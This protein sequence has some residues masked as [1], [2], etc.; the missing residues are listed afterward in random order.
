MAKVKLLQNLISSSDGPAC[1]K[2]TETSQRWRDTVPE[3]YPT[4]EKWQERWQV[5]YPLHAVW[6][7]DTGI[8][9][10][11]LVFLFGHRL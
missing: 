2:Y 8:G 1:K 10:S 3:D 11:L 6:A 5:D 7:T 9:Y 4:M